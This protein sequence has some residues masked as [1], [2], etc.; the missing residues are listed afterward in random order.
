MQCK[1]SNLSN[2]TPFIT[3]L[4]AVQKKQYHIPISSSWTFYNAGPITATAT[5]Q[6][7]LSVVGI[8][9]SNHNQAVLTKTVCDWDKVGF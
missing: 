9:Q 5:P 1:D 7:S 8:D 2:H 4:V 6:P 3:E